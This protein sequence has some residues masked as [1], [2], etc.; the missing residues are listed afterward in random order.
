[1]MIT[2]RRMRASDQDRDSAA[3]LLSEAYAVGRLSRKELDELTGAAY[4]ARTWGELRDLF[5][6]LPFP[7]A[8][9]PADIMAARRVP[10]KTSRGLIG[11][12]IWIFVLALAAGVAGLVTPVAVWV[13]WVL[14]PLALLL[15][16]ALVM[17]LC[18]TAGA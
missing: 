15:P 17:M 16:F 3:E 14:I 4:S 2:D 10:R 13:A 18:S 6:D 5:A 8:G 9:L 1:M 11:Q 12:M 7:G